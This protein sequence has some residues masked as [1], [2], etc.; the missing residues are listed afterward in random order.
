MSCVKG[1]AAVQAVVSVFSGF[2]CALCVNLLAFLCAPTAASSASNPFAFL[3]ARLYHC[4]YQCSSA[5]ICGEFLLLR[6]KPAAPPKIAP[7]GATFPRAPHKNQAPS[8]PSP[9]NPPQYPAKPP[10]HAKP[11]K[12]P[13]SAPDPSPRSSPAPPK[14]PPHPKYRPPLG[15]P[16]RYVP[17]TPAVA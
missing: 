1:P 4:L 15:T 17:R 6:L 8:K 3:F 10:A 7:T 9:P 14:I 5:F 12:W 13:S 11:D 2:L 16:T